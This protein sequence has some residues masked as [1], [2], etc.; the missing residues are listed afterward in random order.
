MFK[1]RKKHKPPVAAKFKIGDRV[2]VRRGVRDE[3][4]PDMPLGGWAGTIC[5]IHK[6]GVYSVRWS[7]ETLANIHPIYKKRCA[8]NGAVLEEYWHL[9]DDLEPDPGGPLAIEQPTQITPRPLSA[10]NQGDRVRMVFGL[11]SDDFLP[12]VDE[13]SLETYYDH[14][15]EQMSL[16]LEARYCPQEDLF[17][18]SPARR[19]KV[20]A[21][22]RE[23]AWDENEGVLC[24]I[25]TAEGEEVV[26][27]TDLVLRRSDP[28]HQLVDDFAAWFVGDLSED[29]DDEWDDDED[30]EEEDEGDEDDSDVLEAAT[31]KTA[32]L[33]LLELTAFATSFG[34]VVGSAVAVMPWARWAVCIGGGVWGVFLAVSQVWYVQKDMRFVVPRFQKGLDGIIGLLTGAVQGAFFG[35]MAVAFVG[36]ALGG[37]A[38]VVLRRLFGR[39][40]WLVRHIFPKSVLF[41]AACGVT[42]QAFFLNR[43]AATAGLWHGTLIGLGSG[44]FLC[45]VALPLAFIAVRRP[46]R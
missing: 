11:T 22:D 45:L 4:H 30:V 7:R 44:L 23:V 26:P 16:P 9:E 27:L 36:A 12:A 34:A 10:K 43:P 25:C 14:L 3:D 18:P 17:N 15:V 42:A 33:A 35:I 29:V 28:N 20:V 41:A 38:G 13:D 24:D 31:W 5:E 32:A 6:R 19:V 1:R 39:K 40:K 21:L 2:R 8:I 46:L 37:I